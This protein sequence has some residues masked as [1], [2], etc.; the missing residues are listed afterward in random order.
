MNE[1]AKQIIEAVAKGMTELAAL[2]G[3]VMGHMA[4]A[5]FRALWGLVQAEERRAAKVLL[6]KAMTNDE[7]VVHKRLI[8]DRAVAMAADQ[9]TA[10]K[11]IA[12]FVWLVIRTLASAVAGALIP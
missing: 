4:E 3:N 8:T 9:A 10:D 5:E 11:G 2:Y 1:Q 7:R 6:L 12:E